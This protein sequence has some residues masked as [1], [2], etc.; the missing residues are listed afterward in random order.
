VMK[1]RYEVR[2]PGLSRAHDETSAP[3]PAATP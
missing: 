3:A 2:L 1:A